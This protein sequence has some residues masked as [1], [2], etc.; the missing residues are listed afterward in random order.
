M[1]EGAI[2]RLGDTRTGTVTPTAAQVD[3]VARGANVR[4][5]RRYVIPGVPA[6]DSARL[7]AEGRR[8]LALKD[9]AVADGGGAAAL[10][11]LGAGAAGIEVREPTA[12]TRQELPEQLAAALWRLN[13]N[14]LSDPLG[15]EGGIQ[16]F[17]RVP[18]ASAREAITAWLTPN[19]QRRADGQYIDSIIRG[20]QVVVAQDGAARMREAAVEPGRF[21]SDTPLATWEGGE[22]TTVE[23]RSWLAMMPAPERARLRLASDTNLSQALHLMARREILFDLAVTS[24]IDTVAVL[25][26]LVPVFRERLTALMADA[27]AAGDPTTWFSDVLEGR[28]RF[29]PLPGALSMVLR[30]RTAPVMNDEARIAA[31][32][33]AARNWK[34]PGAPAQP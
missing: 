10:R 14:E 21:A 28:R 30:D 26:E 24:G 25:T 22:L 13:E 18:N 31:T 33:E 12:H 23:T 19:L 20:R 9:R 17:E 8:L 27:Q 34:A 1:M 3:S 4:V 11:N 32:R 15:G 6:S 7:V 16:V 2:Q 5:F 29:T